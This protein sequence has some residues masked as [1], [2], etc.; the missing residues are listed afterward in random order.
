MNFFYTEQQKLI[1]KEARAFAD[2]EIAPHTARWDREES[3]DPDIIPKLAAQGFFSM[4]L[5]PQYG[6]VEMDYI[7]YALAIEELGRADSAIRGIVTVSLGL[8]GKTLQAHGTVEQQQRW[9]P[10]IARA[11]QIGCFALTEPDSGSDAGS[12]RTTAKR[13][14]DSTWILHGCK[15]FITN[16]TWATL[17]LVF[18]RTSDEGSRGITAFIVPTDTPGFQAQPITGKLGLR[19]QPTATIHLDQVRIPDSCRLGEVG[20]G[21][22]I[23]MGALA[24]GR[25]SVA[26]G[27][28]G[29]AQA[30]LD[31]ATSYAT[32]RTQFSVPIASHQLVQ[33][34]L[35]QSYVEIE[36]AR[37]LT[38]R[39]AALLDA[40]VST[41]E[42]AIPA[43][44]AK[45]A[46]SEA[47]VSV[48]NKCLEVLGGYGFIDEFPLGKFVRDARV[49][50]LYEG[51][52]QIQ[53]LI[54]G[55]HLTGIDALTVGEAS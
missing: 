35:A 6:G 51:T 49:M 17:A 34:L 37:L 54:I 23:A 53:Q 14:A 45:Y 42:L 24:R 50:T 31:Y 30:S 29:I 36:A 32:T 13:Q 5:P 48:S 41:K 22:S 46:A 3:V 52:S 7:S 10:G 40:Q 26:A 39:A 20:Q 16:G 4:T 55:R 43:S 18:A 11:E 47:A 15:T 2:A 33:Q 28:V 19:G 8:V 25:V 9:L 27:S 12:L 38:H 21:F 1:Q 44:I